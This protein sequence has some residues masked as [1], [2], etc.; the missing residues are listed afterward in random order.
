MEQKFEYTYSAKE[1]SELEKIRKKERTK[2]QHEVD[3][4]TLR[5]QRLSQRLSGRNPTRE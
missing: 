2:A 5:L 3:K 1:K 4:A